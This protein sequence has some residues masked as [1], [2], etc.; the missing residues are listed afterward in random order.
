M[1]K[2]LNF[3]TFEMIESKII[4]KTKIEGNNNLTIENMKINLKKFSLAYEYGQIIKN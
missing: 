4:R 2:L 3:K 1:G